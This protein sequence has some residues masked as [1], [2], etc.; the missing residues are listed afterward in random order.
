MLA[1]CQSPIPVTEEVYTA[2]IRADDFNYLADELEKHM[3]QIEAL[4]EVITSQVELFDK[5]RNKIIQMF[6]A[7]YV[8][9][10]FATVSV[11]ILTRE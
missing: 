1:L 5:R 9:L 6:V 7:V 3:R 8:P 2:Q 4:K 11:P 10:A